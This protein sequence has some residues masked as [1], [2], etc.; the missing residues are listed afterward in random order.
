MPMEDSFAYAFRLARLHSVCLV[1]VM[2]LRPPVRRRCPQT[3]V[4]PDWFRGCYPECG[5]VRRNPSGWTLN[6][7]ISIAA[8]TRRLEVVDAVVEAMEKLRSREGEL[9]AVNGNRPV[10][11]ADGWGFR[12]YEQSLFSDRIPLIA[13]RLYPSPQRVLRQSSSS[14]A[15]NVRI[16]AWA[17]VETK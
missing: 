17:P 14:G 10:T 9:V 15:K 16:L 8:V 1:V 2:S 7:C 4:R 3:M 11:E 6:T 13:E 5:T 12:N